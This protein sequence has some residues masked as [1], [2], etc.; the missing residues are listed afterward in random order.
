MRH[1]ILEEQ[2]LHSSELVGLLGI[3]SAIYLNRKLLT[4][5]SGELRELTC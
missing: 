3:E 1:F 5:E 2:L 4:H